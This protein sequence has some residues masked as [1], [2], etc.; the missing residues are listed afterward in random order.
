MRLVGFVGILLLGSVLVC[1]QPVQSVR[2]RIY[3]YTTIDPRTFEAAKHEAADRLQEAG[4]SVEW[5][6]C[7]IHARPLS[8]DACERPFTPADFMVNIL[9]RGMAARF[10]HPKNALAFAAVSGEPMADRSVWILYDAI[11]GLGQHDAAT[12]TIA[13]DVVA[14]ELAH[15]LLDSVEHADAGIM[16]AAWSQELL[17]EAARGQLRFT[18]EAKSGMRQGLNQRWLRSGN[19]GSGAHEGGGK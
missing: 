8:N 11:R 19:Q 3:D 14:H 1:A 10:A 9:P 17:R 6:D 15:L 16:R 18:A 5:I 13:G 7:R 4:I 12:A 2:V